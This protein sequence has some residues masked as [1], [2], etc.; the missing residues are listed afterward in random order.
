LI[1]IRG[2]EE[3]KKRTTLNCD[4]CL[5]IWTNQLIFSNIKYIYIYSIVSFLFRR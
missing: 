2:D 1:L 3:G 5:T 4:H